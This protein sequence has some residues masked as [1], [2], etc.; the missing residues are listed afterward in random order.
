MSSLNISFGAKSLLAVGVG[1]SDISALVQHGR[2][3][4]NWLRV[5]Q[6]DSELFETIDKVY[7]AVLKPRGLVDAALME[8]R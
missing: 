5:A 8:N 1:L 6:N 3:F 7:G 2:T 4:G